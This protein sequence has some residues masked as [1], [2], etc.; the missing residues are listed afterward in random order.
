MDCSKRDNHCDA[1]DSGTHKEMWEALRNLVNCQLDRGDSPC[2]CDSYDP[3]STVGIDYCY[4]ND[5]KTIVR[6]QEFTVGVFELAIDELL[7]AVDCLP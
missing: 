7:L 6:Y 3:V 4:L 5:I 2:V 1:S